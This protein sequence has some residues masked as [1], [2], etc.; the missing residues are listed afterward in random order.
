MLVNY[1]FRRMW[2]KSSL[3]YY[4]GTHLY[5]NHP[6]VQLNLNSINNSGTQLADFNNPVKCFGFHII[7]LKFPNTKFIGL[8]LLLDIYI[9]ILCIETLY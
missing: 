2:T 7:S 3:Q 1:E 9:Y 5:V 6:V 8:T 4:A